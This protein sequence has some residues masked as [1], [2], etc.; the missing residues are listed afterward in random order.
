MIE[1]G[2]IN[3]WKNEIPWRDEVQVEQDLVLSRALVELFQQKEIADTCTLRG[4]T[5]LNKVVFGPAALRWYGVSKPLRSPHSDGQTQAG[6]QY[7]GAWLGWQSCAG[8]IPNG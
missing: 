4:G 7:A 5:A 8:S 6:N 1:R 2:S 3:L